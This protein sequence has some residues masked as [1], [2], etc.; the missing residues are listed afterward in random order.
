MKNFMRYSIIFTAIISVAAGCSVHRPEKISLSTNVPDSFTASADNQ[1]S[2]TFQD[3]WWE[4]FRD[5]NLNAL[6]DKAFSGN[7]DLAQ[8]YSRL[9]QLESLAKQTDAGRYPMI[10]I[11]GDASRSRQLG[12]PNDITGNAYSLSLAAAFEVDLW[13][14]LKSKYQAREFEK[15]ASVQDIRS[16][17]LTLSAQVADLYYLMVEQRAQL[18]LTDR[19]VAARK[20]T[21]EL[22]ER[23]YLEGMVSAL[24]VYQ[25]RQTLAAAQSRRPEFEKTLTVTAHALSILIGDYPDPKARG[26]LAMLPDVP[27]LFPTGLPSE[28]LVRR[29]DIQSELLRLRARD[30]EIGVAVADRFPSINLLA[31][32][33]RYGSDFGTS[34][35]G[36]VWNLVG[37][38]TLPLIDWG[39]RKAEVDRTQAVFQEQLDQYRQTVLVAFKEVEDALISN[40]KTEEAIGWLKNEET[41]AD[42]AL[43]LAS[44][45]YLDGLSD[46]LPVLTAQAL[47]FD[48]QNRLLSTRRQLISDRISLARALG[49]SWM[50]ADIKKRLYG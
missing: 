14:K 1:P 33:G 7:L 22:V 24:D 4:A 40:R 29:P 23:R 48:A 31:D 50:D 42:S 28:L 41:A 32:Y 47:H 30:E 21:V 49:G 19:T 34:L 38:L 44:D 8:A 43:R 46:Y 10:N 13:N 39:S 27:D 2:I 18:E 15:E 5:E 37:N 12:N 11:E 26:S 3:R 6:M 45:R 36:T 25:A 35:S 16:L 17:Y 9:K 20:A